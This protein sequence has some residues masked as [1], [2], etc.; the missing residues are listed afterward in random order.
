M[1]RRP[2]RST[3]FPYTTLFRSRIHLFVDARDAAHDGWLDLAQLFGQMLRSVRD[4]RL[5]AVHDADEDLVDPAEDVRVRKPR[6][7]R[8]LLGD[9]VYL[10]GGA[11][12]IDQVPMAELDA[13][14]HSGG[15]RGIDDGAEVVWLDGGQARA[16]LG[17]LGRFPPDPPCN[18]AVHRHDL[19]QSCAHLQ[20]RGQGG[21]GR[22]RQNRI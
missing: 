6:E 2:P 13:L 4:P 17:H 8:V 3:L 22:D 15:A 1:I 20:L 16:Y 21:A 7:R 9:R 12:D 18:L 10:D 11:A 14:G 19:A 5:T